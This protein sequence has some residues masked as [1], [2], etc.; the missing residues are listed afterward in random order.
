MKRSLLFVITEM[1]R[2]GAETT[3]VNLLKS[4]SCDRFDV[5]L[6]VLSQISMENSLLND[7]PEWVRICNAGL[8][9][10]PKRIQMTKE[11]FLLGGRIA[12]EFVQ[13]KVYDIAFSYGE[14]CRLS[15]VA[16]RV[17]ATRKAVWIHTDITASPSFEEQQFFDLFLQYRYYIF[18]SESTKRLAESRYPFLVGK[19]VLIHNFLDRE[20]LI[21]L[22]EKGVAGFRYPDHVAR[23]ITIANI[24]SEKGY[25]RVVE[26]AHILKEEGF[27]FCWLCIGAFSDTVLERTLREQI[28]ALNLSEQLILLGSRENPHPYTKMADVFVLLSDYEAWPLAMAEAMLLGKPAIAT[29]TSG[30]KTHIRNMENGILCGFDPKDSAE[31]IKRFFADKELRTSIE[32]ETQ[33]YK[34]AP[35]ALLEFQA[36]V[37]DSLKSVP[38]KGRMDDHD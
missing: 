25:Q 1:Y 5:D 32:K 28:H 8:K 15:F 20:K 23:L 9:N 2:G 29:N 22:S 19:S 3:L 14:W 4:L 7:L 11:E 16:E 12:E 38:E 36:F 34:G 30:A 37:E 17:K 21:D 31:A 24:R 6:L 13:D 33:A 18:V 10:Y 35:Q 27:S 26:T